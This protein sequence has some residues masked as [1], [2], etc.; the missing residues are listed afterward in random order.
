MHARVC[1]YTYMYVYM[2]TCI[3]HRVKNMH[4]ERQ[5]DRQSGGRVKFKKI[6]FADNFSKLFAKLNNVVPTT[7]VST[8]WHLLKLVY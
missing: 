2:H 4:K 5:T 8:T 1:A 6:I 3:N 7:H